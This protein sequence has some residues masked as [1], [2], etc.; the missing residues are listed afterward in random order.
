MAQARHAAAAPSKAFPPAS[1][2]LAPMRAAPN[3]DHE[4]HA[5]LG[6]PFHG[7]PH[8]SHHFVGLVRRCFEHQFI[9][10]GEQHFGLGVVGFEAL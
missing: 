8:G 7:A 1:I 9:V 2:V 5:Q 4:R 3:I 10:H 6:D